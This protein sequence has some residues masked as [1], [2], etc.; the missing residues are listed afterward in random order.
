MLVV[1]VFV[2]VILCGFFFWGGGGVCLVGVGYFIFGVFFGGCV[3]T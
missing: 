2:V 3:G 1:V